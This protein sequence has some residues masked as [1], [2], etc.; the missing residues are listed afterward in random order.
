MLW[1]RMFASVRDNSESRIFPCSLL[2][3]IAAKNLVNL[4]LLY[5]TPHL[6]EILEYCT[7]LQDICITDTDVDW[8]LAS[9]ILRNPL[10]SSCIFS[11][12]KFEAEALDF[13][14]EVSSSISLNPR[15][16]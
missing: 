7:N 1:Y 12:C 8:D 9:L 3:Q 15:F 4:E 2:H 13:F 6:K 14:F 16:S 11:R 10:A 5:F